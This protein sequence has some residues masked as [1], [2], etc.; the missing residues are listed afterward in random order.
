MMCA[1]FARWIKTERAGW[2]L[3]FAGRARNVNRPFIHGAL[4]ALSLTFKGG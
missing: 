3:R 2:R 1:V 4:T